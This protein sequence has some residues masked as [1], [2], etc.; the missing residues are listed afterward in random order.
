[1]S[2]AYMD[3]KDFSRSSPTKHAP[4]LP[5][6]PALG[7][8][9]FI[10]VLSDKRLPLSHLA[11]SSM[12]I[13]PALIVVVQ[14]LLSRVAAQGTNVIRCID[15]NSWMYDP[16]GHTPCFTAAHL[17]RPCGRTHFLQAVPPGAPPTLTYSDPDATNYDSC[18]CSTAVYMLTSACGA[19]QGHPW[20]N[21]TSW[22]RYCTP[23]M[24]Y[25]VYPMDV[26][27]GVIVPEWAKANVS[28]LA[29]QTFDIAIARL[30]AL[31]TSPSSSQPFPTSASPPVETDSGSSN[32]AK[33]HSK[34]GPIAG[35]VVG[36]LAFLAIA[37]L[38][39]VWCLIL[40]KRARSARGVQ[41]K[42][43]FRSRW[44]RTSEAL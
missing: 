7:F 44:T 38:L 31:A 26:P 15:E 36:G 6:A 42:Q 16:T 35:G 21:Y 24:R 14:L 23:E 2:P 28:M 22:S 3:R 19:C 5:Q 39:L 30:A 41:E 25:L 1:M 4:G 12:V 33:G 27:A 13:V 18:A 32:T 20:V 8:Y 34:A 43:G 29:G 17:Y 11:A 40:R 9:F 10:A 37:A